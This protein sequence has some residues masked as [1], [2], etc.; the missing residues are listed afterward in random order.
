MGNFDP[1]LS[2]DGLGFVNNRLCQSQLSIEFHGGLRICL[3]QNN[4][5][6]RNITAAPLLVRVAN[7]N[8]I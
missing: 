3:F 6:Y 2:F 1:S 7:T 5:A 4:L 8:D